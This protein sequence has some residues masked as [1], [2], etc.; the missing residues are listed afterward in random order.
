VHFDNFL[1]IRLLRKDKHDDGGGDDNDDDDD[2]DDG[3]VEKRVRFL[4]FIFH[5]LLS[6]AV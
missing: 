3:G 1:L 2:D 4:I 6:I 5:L